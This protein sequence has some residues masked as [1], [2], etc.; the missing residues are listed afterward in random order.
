MKKSIMILGAGIYQVPLIKKA[1]AMGLETLVVSPKGNY[2]GIPLADIFLDIDT[3]D[4]ARVVSVAKEYAIAGIVTTGTDVSVPT[5]GTVVDALHLKGPSRD[6]AETVSSKSAFRSFLRRNNLNHPD[7]ISCKSYEEIWAFYQKLNVKM[8]VKP[9]DSSGSRGV[10]VLDPGQSKKIVMDAYQNA[11]K[12][13]RTGRVCAEEFIPGIEVGGEA[14]L[15]YG[16]IRLF[17]VTCKHVAG[18][19]VQ[20]H[21]L[22]GRLTE[23]E[24]LRVKDEINQ[25]A[26]KLSYL[27]GP[28]NFDVMLSENKATILEM[29]LR[30]GGNGII[31]LIYHSCG[32]DLT[33]W[34]LAYALGEPVLEEKMSET[35][36]K[37]SYVFGSEH[38]GILENVS[39]L[40][41]LTSYVP[42]VFDMVLAK[43]PG[44]HVDAFI[45]NANLIGYLLLNCGA[46]DYNTVVSRI[47][48]VL[49]VK[50]K[51]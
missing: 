38:T 29:G 23:M 40:K 48:E 11:V 31:D 36:E 35:K 32:I 34:L 19:M 5:V 21:S 28:V 50:V 25:V 49:Q 17:T 43:H 13:S 41:E 42:Q 9:D 22:P 27:N 4:V 39:S 45:H 20:G 18:V 15:Q 24:T 33:K 8:V 51:V 6:M 26:S 14:F 7:F 16:E 37:S 30:N 47:R 12:F 10:I 2:P 1:K 46:A 3:T 44:D